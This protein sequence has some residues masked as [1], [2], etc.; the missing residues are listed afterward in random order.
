MSAFAVIKTGGKQYK[1]SVGEKLTIEKL[2]V[3]EG[4][5]VEFDEVLMI[6]DE[7]KGIVKIGRPFINGA[8]VVAKALGEGKGD[9]VTIV[10][11]KAKKRY[12]KKQGHRQMFTEVEIEQIDA[13]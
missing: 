3:E 11:F 8:K 13:V 9:K 10:K 7:D 2:D 1:V 6:A 12:K 5:S 4:K